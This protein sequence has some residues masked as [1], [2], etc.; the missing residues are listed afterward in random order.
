MS[1]SNILNIIGYI[2]IVIFIRWVYVKLI[3]KTNMEQLVTT[4]NKDG[5]KMFG[6]ETCGWTVKQLQVF[7]AYAKDITFVDCKKSPDLCAQHKISGFPSWVDSKGNVY[8][9]YKSPAMLTQMV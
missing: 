7:G 3:N 8:P 6:S 9:G 1:K 5:W 4:L 2:A